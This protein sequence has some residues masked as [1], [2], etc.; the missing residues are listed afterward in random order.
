MHVIQAERDNLNLAE[1]VIRHECL[2]VDF[3]RGDLCETHTSEAQ[4]QAASKKYEAWLAARARAGL[5]D[6]SHGTRFVTDAQEAQKV[7]PVVLASSWSAETSSTL[8][9]SRGSRVP[10]RCNFG[11]PAQSTRATFLQRAPQ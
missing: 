8:P 3:W 6:D 4:S 11:P 2:D 5:T 7:S 10:S 1:A 9:R